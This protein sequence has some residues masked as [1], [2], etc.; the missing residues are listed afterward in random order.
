MCIQYLGF[1]TRVLV[2]DHSLTLP[3]LFVPFVPFFR[4]YGSDAIDGDDG[5]AE[6]D[7]V[8]VGVD[9]VGVDAAR[10]DDEY[11]SCHSRAATA[12]ATTTTKTRKDVLR[13][14]RRRVG[15]RDGGCR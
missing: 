3:A 9:F 13:S 6:N 14:V 4:S 15:T 5:D 10:D 12:A 1:G 2:V 7:P 11:C 8:D